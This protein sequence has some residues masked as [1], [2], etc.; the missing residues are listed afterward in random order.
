MVIGTVFC[1]TLAAGLLWNIKLLIP[2]A[3]THQVHHS[4]E[5]LTTIAHTSLTEKG[6]TKRRVPTIVIA[7]AVGLL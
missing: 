3:T 4:E 6:A 2:S 5:V 7:V 1:S